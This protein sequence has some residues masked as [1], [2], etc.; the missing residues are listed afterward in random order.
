MYRLMKLAMYA[1]I[2]Y[3]LYEL[4]QGISQG[5]RGGGAQWRPGSQL[6]RALNED[7]GRY[8]ALTGGGEGETTTSDEPAGTSVP[9]RVGRGVTSS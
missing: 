1:L 8:G 3:A 5:G 6:D 2:G 9:H 4:F 7:Q